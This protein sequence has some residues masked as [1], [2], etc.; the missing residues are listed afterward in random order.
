MQNPSREQDDLRTK[1][2]PLPKLL[3]HSY[4][5]N[6]KSPK[7]S[8]M[9]LEV[10][11]KGPLDISYMCIR[12]I[13]FLFFL[14]LLLH[15]TVVFLFMC[16]RSSTTSRDEKRRLPSSTVVKSSTVFIWYHNLKS[17]WKVLNPS[18][19]IGCCGKLCD[20]VYNF[21]KIEVLCFESSHNAQELIKPEDGGLVAAVILIVYLC[22]NLAKH[23]STFFRY[24]SNRCEVLY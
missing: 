23:L 13:L 4:D 3:A 12:V 24:R 20:T 16:T 2:K 11:F 9:Y 5:I 14:H 7:N 8:C 19:E 21:R 17:V 15:S 10:I 18:K 6:P 22:W 1:Q